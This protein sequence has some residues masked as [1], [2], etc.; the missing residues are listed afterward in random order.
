MILNF[1]IDYI[2]EI[3]NILIPKSKEKNTNTNVSASVQYDNTYNSLNEADFERDVTSD[4]MEDKGPAN[5]DFS[6]Y[7]RFEYRKLIGR[8]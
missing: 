2:D 6:E 8:I 7:I 1:Y 5:I 4:R 3:I